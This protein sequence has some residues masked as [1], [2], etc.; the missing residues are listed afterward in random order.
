M[1]EIF[2]DKKYQFVKFTDQTNYLRNGQ[3]LKFIF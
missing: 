3:E 2:C 1:S